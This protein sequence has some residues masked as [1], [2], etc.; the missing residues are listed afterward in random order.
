MAK[1]VLKNISK[2]F[3]DRTVLKNINLEIEDGE[4]VV[5]AGASGCGKS[6][7]LRMIAGLERQTT[8][9]ILI[10]DE[11]VNN[12]SPKDRNIAMV[13][14]SY[15]LYP[16]LTVKENIELSLKI[17]KTPKCEIERRT[18]IAAETLKIEEYLK[19]KPKELSGGQR[20]R[21]ALARA[22]VREPKVFLMDEPLSNLDAKLRNEM[23]SVIKRLH[24][25]LNTTFIYVTHD[26]TEALTMGDKIVVLNKGDIQQSD[27]ADMIYNH[28]KNAF[29]ASFMGTNPMNIAP[30]QIK[31]GL[32][33]FGNIALSIETLPDSVRNLKDVLIGVR[34]ES[35]IDKNNPSYP[36]NLIKFSTPVS[37][38]ENLG[39]YKN[40]YF[41]MGEKDFIANINN[42]TTVEDTMHFSINPRNLYF[43]DSKT[44]ENLVKESKFEIKN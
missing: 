15:A 25:K 44:G 18:T 35:I 5:L 28:P 12:V 23:R 38:E 3:G 43:F 36:F 37:F 26:Q 39:S 33:T 4:F 17:K 10:D 27:S 42:Q 19:A 31:D 7:L 30:A 9:D 24:K 40:V 16:H 2:N 11:V 32:L 14:Q 34:P 6:T 8:G 1:V 20:Q 13:F 41:K 29:V 21:V 22:I